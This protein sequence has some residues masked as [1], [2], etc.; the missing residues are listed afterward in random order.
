MGL[1]EVPLSTP[2]SHHNDNISMKRSATPASGWEDL[3]IKEA[4]AKHFRLSE[5]KE[6]GGAHG[7][8]AVNHLVDLAGS[9]LLV[10][11]CSPE[12]ACRVVNAIRMNAGHGTGQLCSNTYYS[13]GLAIWKVLQELVLRLGLPV[14]AFVFPRPLAP[15]KKKRDV[16]P[17]EELIAIQSAVQ[18]LIAV[19]PTWRFMDR[20]VWSWLSWGLSPRALAETKMV[21][22][23]FENGTVDWPCED[24]GLIIQE[25]MVCALAQDWWKPKGDFVFHDCVN[26]KK[27]GEKIKDGLR[28]LRKILGP[29]CKGVPTR[30]NGLILKI[31]EL[32]AEG[33]L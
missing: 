31:Q 26:A 29:E 2:Y 23:D 19:D 14:G 27:G 33:E 5:Y 12:G 28:K 8:Y 16:L 20:V 13:Y 21:D 6:I 10:R 15:K 17:V 24:P 30:I 22:L 32:K 7:S 3:S 11:L 9:E 18:D 4:L 25:D 1:V